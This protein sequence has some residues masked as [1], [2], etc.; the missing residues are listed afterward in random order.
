MSNDWRYINYADWAL[1]ELLHTEYD[2]DKLIDILDGC[3]EEP[4][5][6]FNAYEVLDCLNEKEALI[7]ELILFEGRTYISVGRQVGLSKQRVHQIY[8]I[9]LDKIKKKGVL[10]DPP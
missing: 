4:P 9:A 10:N 1:D 8:T 2:E 5:P 7:V 6:T 3:S